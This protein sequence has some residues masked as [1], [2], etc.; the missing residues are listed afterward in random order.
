MIGI[1]NENTNIYSDFIK[2]KKWF[3]VVEGETVLEKCK[4]ILH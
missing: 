2:L 3:N 1:R 4:H